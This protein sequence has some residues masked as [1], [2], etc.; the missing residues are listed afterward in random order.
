[1]ISH[2]FTSFDYAKLYYRD[3]FNLH[4]LFACIINSDLYHSKFSLDFL[5]PLNLFYQLFQIATRSLS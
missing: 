4:F 5:L 3:S 2:Y 1:M